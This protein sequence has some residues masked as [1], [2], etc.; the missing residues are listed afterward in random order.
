MSDR[1][2]PFSTWNPHGFEQHRIH[3]RKDHRV[4]AN[5]HRQR[6]HH[7]GGEPAMGKNHTH[8]EA[9]IICHEI[10]LREKTPACSREFSRSL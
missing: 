2:Q 7:G 9:Q 8:R 3:Q 10:E 6:R 4:E 5:P 1:H